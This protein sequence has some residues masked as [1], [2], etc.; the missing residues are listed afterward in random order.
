MPHFTRTTCPQCGATFD[1]RRGEACWCAAYPPLLTAGGAAAC[2]C[3]GCL[4]ERVAAAI[5]AFVE[6]YS[7]GRAENIAPRYDRGSK[8]LLEGIDYY[9]ERGRYVFTAWYHLK[10]GT[11]CGSGCRHCPYGH[12]NVP[13]SQRG[14]QR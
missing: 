7:A 3:P 4:H 2:L 10:R 8:Q 1:C 14:R 5:E 13:G 12:V 11:C 9:L 6:D